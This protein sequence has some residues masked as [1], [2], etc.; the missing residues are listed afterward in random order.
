V[1][2]CNG[3]VS[4]F[5]GTSVGLFNRNYLSFNTSEGSSE[6]CTQSLGVA[7]LNRDEKDDLVFL[8]TGVHSAGVL[9][10]ASCDE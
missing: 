2:S 10:V 4:V 6:Q 3:T 7:D 8:N 5:L 1:L 9:L